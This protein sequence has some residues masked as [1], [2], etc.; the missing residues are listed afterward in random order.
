MKIATWNVNSI[1][2]RLEQVTDWLQ[3]NPV[4]VLCLQETKV[5][6]ADFP[7]SALEALGYHLYISGQ[8]SY[9]GV[10]LLS[11]IPLT[12]VSIGFTPILGP[13]VAELD[14]QKRVITGTFEDI[15]ILNLYV[16]NGSA[17]GSDKYSYKL[18]W[19]KTLQDYLKIILDKTD[20]LCIC[21]DFNIALEAIDI[22]RKT[23][24]NDI[25]AS[26]T[27][28][29]ALTNI[30]ELGLTD[31]FRLFNQ[32]PGQF[33]WWDYRAGSFARNRGWRIDHHYVTP[34]LKERAIACTI[35]TEPRKLP[36]PS[37]HTPVILELE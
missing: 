31:A 11:K 6:D 26:P 12:D 34:K 9:N 25:M 14:E 32:E 5:V 4:E 2:T 13:E 15:R 24:P 7:R 8:K 22:H 3:T 35:D 30:L 21:G 37:D 19:L 18:T 16:P 23:T 1:R 28:R 10:A 27:E 33:S 20:K 29:A 17:V 36:K